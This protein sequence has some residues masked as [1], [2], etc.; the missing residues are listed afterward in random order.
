MNL[1]MNRCFVSITALL[2]VCNLSASDTA[3]KY[4]FSARDIAVFYNPS[5][6]AVE[7]P[8]STASVQSFSGDTFVAIEKRDY[9]SLYKHALERSSTMEDE[10]SCI[11]S[12]LPDTDKTHK[13]HYQTIYAT[14]KNYQTMFGLIKV[15]E[16][17][18]P[19]HVQLS[20]WDLMHLLQWA[21]DI[22][23]WSIRDGNDDHFCFQFLLGKEEVYASKLLRNF[24]ASNAVY[25]HMQ[26]DIQKWLD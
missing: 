1:V 22:T 8:F 9:E 12:L 25:Q 23:K 16:T 7:S 24:I 11:F 5:T 15:E 21:N 18:N 4:P 19:K 10:A 17:T 3:K 26:K 6:C 20:Q 14:A 2:T 13:L